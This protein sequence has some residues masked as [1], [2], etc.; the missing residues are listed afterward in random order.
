MLGIILAGGTG[1]R[2][3]PLTNVV[4]KQ[5]LPIYDKPMIYYPITT[6]MLAGIKE[7]VV[8]VT[9]EYVEQFRKLL[10]DGSKWGIQISLVVQANPRGIA[11]SFE[12]VPPKF[13]DQDCALILGDNLFYG[14]GLGASLQTV[15]SGSGARIFAYE[16]SNPEDYGVISFD[17]NFEPIRIQEKPSSPESNYAIPGLYFFDKNCY[18]LASELT[19]S[20]RGELE[21]T[22]LLNIY[23]SRKELAV[24]ILARGTAWLDTGSPE[25]L[26]SAAAFVQVIEERQGLKIGCPEEVAV[27]EGFISMTEFKTLLQH[28]PLNSY[29]SYLENLNIQLRR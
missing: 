10:G 15:F 3:A 6:L 26:L 8:V 9:P 25:N 14:M 11:Q 12:L 27:R 23:L 1:T 21:I 17:S 16:V 2:L 7:F 18:K 22:D 5:L 4:S 13:R 19:P 24:Q 28:L 29:R 20:M